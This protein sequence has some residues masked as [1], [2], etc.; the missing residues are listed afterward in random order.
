MTTP[1]FGLL[2]HFTHLDNIPEVLAQGSFLC[3]A[4]VQD[5]GIL[6]V[7]AGDH[8]VK[9][10]RRRREVP[11]APGGVV[12]DYVPF[13]FAARPPMMYVMWK[14]GVPTFDGDI[15]DLVYFVSDVFTASS[16]GQPVV[17]SDRNAAIGIAEFS[18]DLRVLGNLA[19]DLPDCTFVDWSVMRPAMRNNDWDHPDRMDRRTAEFLVHR[20]FPLGS[21]TS[22]GVH[23]PS[24]SAK[25]EQMFDAAGWQVPVEVRPEWYYP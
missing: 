4:D 15:R 20:T 3:D 2:F 1:Q 25:I 21:V 10:R 11:C 9:D 6:T 5:A 16:C 22:V 18:T 12:A 7:E 23:N 19:D 13:Y 14:G 24:V 8:S 17:V